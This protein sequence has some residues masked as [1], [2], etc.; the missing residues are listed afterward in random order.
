LNDALSE[1]CRNDLR[2]YRGALESG[3]P[4]QQ[5]QAIERGS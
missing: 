1:Y 2:I 4:D 3:F 5:W